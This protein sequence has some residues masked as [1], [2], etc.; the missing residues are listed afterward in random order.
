MFFDPGYDLKFSHGTLYAGGRQGENIF[1]SGS[2]QTVVFEYSDFIFVKL[3]FWDDGNHMDTG[4]RGFYEY[5]Y[6]LHDLQQGI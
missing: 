3:P 1:L 4:D 5:G 6:I 2:D